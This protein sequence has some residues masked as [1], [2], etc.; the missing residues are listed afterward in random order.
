MGLNKEGLKKNS[1]GRDLFEFKE[2]VNLLRVLPPDM[3]YFMEDIDYIAHRYLTHW[4]IGPEGA[5]PVTCARSQDDSN[6]CPICDKIRVL[7]RNP[8]FEKVVNDIYP[9]SRY[10]LNVLDVNAPEKGVQWMETGPK[11]YREILKYALDPEY[12]D[13]LDLDKGRNFKVTYTPGSKHSSGYN[14]YDTIPSASESSVRSLLTEGWKTKVAG[15]FESMRTPPSI[16]ELEELARSID[17]PIMDELPPSK[18]KT[19]QA[20][21]P[22]TSPTLQEVQVDALPEGSIKE[23]AVKV[24]ESKQSPLDQS[25]QTQSSEKPCFGKQFSLSESTCKA[26][27]RRGDCMV[28]FTR[29]M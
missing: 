23:D 22:Q 18:P 13:I 12:G 21:S 6:S 17:S 11:I 9:R 15:L 24:V 25:S 29:A 27:A 8:A 10:L 1:I 16:E 7:K 14:Q 26:C 3:K 2:G 19:Q 28:E 20:P 5:P 4:G